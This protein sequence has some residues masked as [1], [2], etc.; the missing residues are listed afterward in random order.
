MKS[1]FWMVAAT[2]LVAMAFSTVPTPL[3]PLYQAEDGF[4]TSM[5]TVAFSAYAV[6][7]LI[8]LFFA[9]HV[10]DWVGRRRVLLP[11][12]LLEV[13]AAVLFLANHELPVLIVARIV[14]GLGTGLITATA[15][16]HLSDLAE[17]AG[18]RNATRV[19]TAVNLGGLGIGP[20]VSGFLAQ[21]VGGPLTTVYAIFL[22]LLAICVLG[23]A[24]VPETVTATRR[25]YRPQ[26]VTVPAEARRRYF[27]AAAGAFI[28][29]ALFGLFSSLTPKLLTASVG[30]TSALLSG[31]V[32]FSV[33]LFGVLAQL[34]SGRLAL[35]R[36]LTVGVT[37]LVGGVVVLLAGGVAG[38]LL[39]FVLG[40]AIAGAGAGL[41]FK[42]AMGSAARLADPA[43]KGEAVS[44]VPILLAGYLG[45]TV[46][47]MGL[48]AA[49]RYVSLTTGLAAFCVVMLVLLGG[50]GLQLRTLRA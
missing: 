2:F 26:R 39:L 14:C 8:S 42:G 35:E 31:A 45:L 27:V 19:A 13:V 48:G 41:L 17:R 50:M 43:V 37:L 49:A 28:S 18:V 44:V 21:Y 40:G 10:S 29:F 32:S 9:G 46:P 30:T 3:W 15:T 6:G 12:V 47:I 24:L 20:L 4:P 36:Q 11:A 33:F 34:G 38:S 23:V 22:V 25:R 5:V 16:A 7:V 1:G